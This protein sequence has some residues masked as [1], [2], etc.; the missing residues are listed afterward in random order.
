MDES[1]KVCD[2]DYE[3]NGSLKKK[4][5]FEIVSITNNYCHSRRQSLFDDDGD[6]TDSGYRGK[7]KVQFPPFLIKGQLT[8]DYNGSKV[9]NDQNSDAQKDSTFNSVNSTN[10]TKITS[11]IADSNS[12]TSRFRIARKHNVSERGRWTCRDYMSVANEVTTC[13]QSSNDPLTNIKE[14]DNCKI[15]QDVNYSNGKQSELKYAL[16]EK[17]MINSSEKKGLQSLALKPDSTSEQIAKTT[18][19]TSNI[20]TSSSRISNNHLVNKCSPQESMNYF[21]TNIVKPGRLGMGIR[22]EQHGM[23][24][25]P[26]QDMNG[27]SP[28]NSDPMRYQQYDV[29]SPNDFFSTTGSPYDEN[30]QFRNRY[31]KYTI[32]K[33]NHDT[34]LLV[35]DYYYI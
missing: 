32:L 20:N 33:T 21:K 16:S 35:D 30:F 12:S 25:K 7:E 34:F 15:I 26:I 11:S 13:T 8:N 2:Y 3:V 29:G 18:V 1:I 22:N 6:E 10:N 28:T 19:Q 31:V 23:F 4:S 5:N 24:F 27:Q 9:I 14:E 17:A